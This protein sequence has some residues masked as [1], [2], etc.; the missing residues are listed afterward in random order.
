MEQV[1]DVYARPYDPSPYDPS[2][3]VVCLDE[4]RKQLVC[5][6]RPP[7]TS[8]TGVRHVDYE[9]RRAGVATLYMLCEPL[10]GYREVRI[11]ERQDRRTW[12]RVVAHLV[13]EVYPN[14]EQIT[15]VQ[16]SLSAH[17]AKALYEVY[18]PERARRILRRL[19]MVWTPVHGSWLN[20]AELELSVL[21]RQCLCTRIPDAATLTER[22]RA[23]E[24]ARNQAQ[25]GVDWQFTTAEARVKLKRLYSTIIT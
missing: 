5:E 11:T 1:L 21:A 23:W 2:H 9:Y 24:R 8:A 10:G 19:R 14:A 15:L 16:D 18:P 13:E 20:I 22:V 3:P 25:T 17:T 4:A 6:V 7:F 12:A